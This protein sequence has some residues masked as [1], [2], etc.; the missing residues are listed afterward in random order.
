MY[1][2]KCSCGWHSLWA[3]VEHAGADANKH[4]KYAGGE[5]KGHYVSVEGLDNGN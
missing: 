2:A 3:T 5:S 1:T 4:S